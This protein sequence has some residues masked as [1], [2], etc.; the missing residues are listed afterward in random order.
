MLIIIA[1][2][3]FLQRLGIPLGDQFVPVCLITS[4]LGLGLVALASEL[5]LCRWRV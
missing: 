2:I 5:T 3:I 4:L 1:G